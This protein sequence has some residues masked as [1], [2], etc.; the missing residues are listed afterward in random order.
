[1][2]TDP[3]AS[4]ESEET[5][6]D[7]PELTLLDDGSIR[8]AVRRGVLLTGIVAAAWL[9]LA[10]VVLYIGAV[11]VVAV[12]T[13]RFH[14]LAYY[15][16]Q[17][18]RPAYAVHGNS[19]C[20]AT[21]GLT[22]LQGLDLQAR[23]ALGQGGQIAGQVRRSLSGTFEST[24][25]QEDATPIG[26]ALQR[27][28]PTKTG[29]STFLQ[30]LPQSVSTSAIVEFS[31]P[32]DQAGLDNFPFA[33]QPSNSAGD[34][35]ALLLSDPYGGSVVSWPEHGVETFSHWVATL[36]SKDENE[37][38]ELGAPSLTELRRA[39]KTP[40]IH[41]VVVQQATVGELLTLL[42]NPQVR[43]VN[44]AEIAFDPGRQSTDN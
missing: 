34:N 4:D 29:T 7:V 35:P 25:P 1:V 33:V 10:T 43:S 14:D 40:R 26:A 24:L 31:T 16:A 37:L 20:S 15:G 28:R 23:G 36:T 30:T 32:L 18:G 9:L 44:V 8:R 6:F 13:E 22:N 38:A 21:F 41:A 2:S 19:C 39:A 27:R 5:P 42:R 17:V 3:T 11:V 12:H